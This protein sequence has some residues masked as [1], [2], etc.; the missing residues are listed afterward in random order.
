MG[1]RP[2]RTSISGSL[3]KPGGYID[4]YFT[5]LSTFAIIKMFFCSETFLNSENVFLLRVLYVKMSLN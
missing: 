2:N 1:H 5:K 3:L 4:A